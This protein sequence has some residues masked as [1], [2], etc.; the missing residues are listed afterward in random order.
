MAGF[1]GFGTE[2]KGPGQGNDRGREG[3]LLILP[4]APRHDP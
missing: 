3:P 1:R 4:S 2:A